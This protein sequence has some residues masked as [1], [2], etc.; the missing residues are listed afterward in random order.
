[1]PGPKNTL[2]HV[3]AV[4]LSAHSGSTTSEKV[5]FY[6]SWADD[7]DQVGWKCKRVKL[8]LVLPRDGISLLSFPCFSQSSICRMW[9]CWSTEHRVWQQTASLPTLS[10]VV[11]KPLCW[12]WPVVQDWWPNRYRFREKQKHCK[13]FSVLVFAN[14]HK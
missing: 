7:Y 3:K 2:E 14:T 9:L 4:I 5:N 12:M 6:N 10:V 11:M 8:L 13:A 1:M